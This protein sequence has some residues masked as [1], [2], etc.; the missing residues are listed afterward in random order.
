VE[1]KVLKEAPGPQRMMAWKPGEGSVACGMLNCVYVQE[2]VRWT[3]IVGVTIW[4]GASHGGSCS[5][6]CDVMQRPLVACS[7]GDNNTNHP[8]PQPTPAVRR[9]AAQL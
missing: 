6:A 3:L 1:V 8:Q 4:R 7:A 9:F 2:Q 5:S